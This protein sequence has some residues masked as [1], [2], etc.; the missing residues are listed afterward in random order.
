MEMVLSTIFIL[1]N[2]AGLVTGSHKISDCFAAQMLLNTC[3][4]LEQEASSQANS[5][6]EGAHIGQGWY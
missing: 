6:L 3:F 4:L 1:I 5:G 2:W